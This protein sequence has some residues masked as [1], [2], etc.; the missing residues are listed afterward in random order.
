[1]PIAPHTQIFCRVIDNYGDLGV[2][3]RLAR[4][5]ACEHG[6]RVTLWVDDWATVQRMTAALPVDAAACAPKPHAT[7]AASA[8]P[9]WRVWPSDDAALVRALA[10][11]PDA[12]RVIEG[13]ACRLPEAALAHFAAQST[14][15]RWFNLEYLT[16]EPWASTCHGLPSPHPRLPLVQ[17]FFFPGFA[18]ASGGLLRENGL[19]QKQ[20]AFAHSPLVQRRFWQSL[21]VAQP[22]DFA[23]KISLFAYQNVG[24]QALL[25]ALASHP[26]RVLL[27]VTDSQHVHAVQ[28]WLTPQGHT[29]TKGQ[30]LV[31]GSLT[32]VRLPFLDHDDFDRLLWACD[33]NLVRGEDSLVRAIWAGQAWLWHIY[34]QDDD[35]HVDKLQALCQQLAGDLGDSPALSLWTQALL[36]YGTCQAPDWGALLGQL[37]A[38]TLLAQRWG[39]QL[40]AQPDL[41][42]QLLAMD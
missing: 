34:P 42:T 29:L 40:A 3:W 2:C 28:D 39:D 23:L 16:A 14:P 13:F 22:E 38:L 19:L 1:M 9:H 37:P 7:S 31:V 4:Q 18:R 30:P 17:R 15:P 36:A 10:M 25:A 35:A 11:L 26:A 33:L 8:L 24:I 27:A 32:L 6:H 21:G 5:L 12:Q 41:C 20:R